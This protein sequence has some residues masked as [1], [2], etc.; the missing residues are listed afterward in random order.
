MRCSGQAGGLHLGVAS[1]G[2]L[3]LKGE[4][5]VVAPEALEHL[6]FGDAEPGFRV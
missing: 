1:H 3:F 4:E 6:V 2:P 5:V